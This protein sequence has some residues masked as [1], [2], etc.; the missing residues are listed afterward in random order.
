MPFLFN[1]KKVDEDGN[2]N[3][4]KKIKKWKKDLI[5]EYSLNEKGGSVTLTYSDNRVVKNKFFKTVDRNV[6]T[7]KYFM[8]ASIGI[9]LQST[10]VGESGNR[11][12]WVYYE[13][14][15]KND[16]GDST[17]QPDDFIFTGIA[18]KTIND[19]DLLVFLWYLSE[20]TQGGENEG[21]KAKHSVKF[22][23]KVKIEEERA[24]KEYKDAILGA[25]IMAPKDQGGLGDDD[26]RTLADLLMIDVDKR[27]AGNPK[28]IRSKVLARLRSNPSEIKYLEKM[29]SKKKL[30][31][32]DKARTI[33]QRAEAQG[34]ILCRKESGI[35]EWFLLDGEGEETEGIHRVKQGKNVKDSL[36]AHLVTNQQL[37]KRIE[38]MLGEDTE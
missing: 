25:K 10:I 12:R 13:T 8:P 2:S 32:A 38:T 28:I 3:P 21:A 20:Y 33:V 26:I 35:D 15:R 34:V 30:T 27:A 4:A 11:E 6:T 1:G 5:E 19:I 18:S 31:L 37:M 7:K 9:P 14:E 22:I 36:A 16:K 29:M 17:F 24:D 23:N